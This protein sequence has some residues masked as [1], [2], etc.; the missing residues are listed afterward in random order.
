MRLLNECSND[1]ING[2]KVTVMFK[3]DLNNLA[4]S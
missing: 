3:N 4:E 2:E 1:F